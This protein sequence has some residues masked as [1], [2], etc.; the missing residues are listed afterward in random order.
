[1]EG[2]GNVENGEGVDNVD[3]VEVVGDAAFVKVG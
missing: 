3:D 1:M 2:V